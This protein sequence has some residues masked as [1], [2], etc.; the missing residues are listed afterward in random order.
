MTGAAPHERS[1]QVR[2]VE[3]AIMSPG[4]SR[5]EATMSTFTTFWLSIKDLFDELFA[6]MIV[7]L[8][9]VAISAPLAVAAGLLI[10]TG[11]LGPGVL[12]ALLAVLP[13]APA[14]AGLYTVVQRVAEGR[15][16]TWRLFF[17]G[18]REYLMPSW[19]VYGLWAIGL[20]LILVN[21]QFYNRISSNI[22]QFLSIL[23]LYVLLVWLALLIYIGPLLL[24][25]NDKRIRVI[26]RNAFLMAVGRPIFTLV[27]LIMMA[28]IFVASIWLVILPFILTFAFL[29]L[30]SF[31]ATTRLIAD[32]EARRAAREEKVAADQPPAK[33]RGG[34]IRPRD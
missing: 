25:Q 32:A 33:G 4:G 15:V 17:T 19:R 8:L 11:S 10:Y 18:F 22:G 5:A 2:R 3:H 1:M 28:V 20:M 9:W 31:R 6:L 21:V 13:A 23:F 26:A 29:A 14:T 7:N 12:V 24:L 27:T 34:Q 16:A 30:W